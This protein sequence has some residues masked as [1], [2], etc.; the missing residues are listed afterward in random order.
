MLNRYYSDPQTLERYRTGPVGE[1]L[2]EFI[3]WLEALGFRYHSIR[4]IVRGA[5]AFARWA[6]KP[7]DQLNTEALYGFGQHLKID[8]HL[9][10]PS[11]P[12]NHHYI[13]AQHFI[14]FLEASN[15]IP[16]A[17]PVEPT[18]DEP[19]LWYEFR[20]WMQSQRGTM[21][22]TLNNYR[23]TIAALIQ[24]MGDQPAQYNAVSLREFVLNRTQQQS[25]GSAKNTVTAVRMLIRF[26]IATHRCKL[27]LDHALPTIAH[28]RLASLPK[29]L[30]TEE[31]ERTIS[32]CRLTTLIGVR[33][34]AV[35]LLLA[36]LGLRAGD[37]AALQF[38][39]IDWHN[40]TVQVSGKNRCAERL[41]LAQEVGDAILDYL[42]QRPALENP[43]VFITT[44]YP[45]KGLSYQ[46]VG[47]IATHA[48]QRAGIKTQ[49]HGAHLLRH[50]AASKMLRQGLSLPT[51]GALLR[52]RS[53]ETTTIYAKIDT[54]LLAQVARPWP[55]EVSC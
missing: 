12:Y 37:V 35:L 3:A 28:W 21:M 38:E 27:G 18:S 11:G 15:Q 6:Q 49:T 20:D 7:I 43:H 55:E 1:H 5:S 45:L 16:P 53:I 17:L 2:D 24:A 51:I 23:L 42:K 48:M 8:G 4:R 10:Y 41:P 14:H 34:R 33:D 39:H 46:T 36:R 9:Q 25:I 31:V 13:S 50:S 52:H 26:L 19:A 22:V 30:T 47:Q 54:T 40:A 44:R 29:Y 32:G